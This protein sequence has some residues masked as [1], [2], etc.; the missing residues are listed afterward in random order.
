MQSF[1]KTCPAN[2]SMSLAWPAFS[3]KKSFLFP[4]AG[5]RAPGETDST[6]IGIYSQ[7]GVT[8]SIALNTLRRPTAEKKP[9]CSDFN[10]GG[11]SPIDPKRGRC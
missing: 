6:L 4:L 9:L 5:D 10:S 1:P 11:I 3:S 7:T 2:G 8:D